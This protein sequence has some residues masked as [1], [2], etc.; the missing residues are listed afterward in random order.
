MK[1]G[2]TLYSYGRDLSKGK[3]TIEEAI[4]HAA[5]CGAKCIETVDQCHFKEWPHP[6]L[7]DLFRI[8]NLIESLGMEWVNWSQY[9]EEE[10]SADYKCS[11]DDMV[12]QVKESIYYS[13]ILGIP[14]TRITPF[15]N[16]DPA[17]N[18]VIERCLPFAEKCNVIMGFEIHSPQKPDRFLE[19]IKQ[20]NSK[21]LSVVPDFSAWAYDMNLSLD[22]F[23]DCLPYT[24][25]IHGKSHAVIPEG[26]DEPTI[27]Y[28]SLMTV[29]KD[30]KY[31]GSIVA[32]YEPRESNADT[33]KGVES[34]V[35]YIY[36]FV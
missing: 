6:K 5:G 35:K 16:V 1:V 27:P 32:E 9:T 26:G 22:S 4:E 7:A 17:K 12:D 18:H 29:L 8:K 34:L 11:E 20:F 2:V 3:I 21:F 30:Y 36:S 31:S 13:H 10:Y 24:A 23:R 33:R 19:L 25:H 15:P 14:V 28:K